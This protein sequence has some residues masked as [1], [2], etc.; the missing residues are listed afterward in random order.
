MTLVSVLRESPRSSMNKN[1]QSRKRYAEHRQCLKQNLIAKSPCFQIKRIQQET[2]IGRPIPDKPPPPYTPPER[3]SQ[4]VVP[5]PV[6]EKHV[7]CAR[8]EIASFV[9]PLAKTLYA[10]KFGTEAPNVDPPVAK[11]D[12]AAMHPSKK[13]FLSFLSDFTAEIF[14]EIYACEREEQNPPWMPQKPLAK[15]LRA[16]P[17]SSAE[18]ED[19][20]R[21]EALIHFGLE[22][23]S[24]KEN[25]IVRWSQRKRDR[26]DQILVRE[27][28]G[29]E[30]GWTDYSK[31]EALVKDQ[32]SKAILDL[33]ID[34]T[35]KELTRLMS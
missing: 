20:V 33:L 18:L 17:K 25:L 26:V 24:A 12:S 3:V 9:T 35:V 29:E 19:R 32:V 22:R 5:R 1:W 8:D 27:L 13:V 28:H 30:V 11:D 34:D 6:V 7:P 23:R 21:R 31:D 4:P 2:L 15:A 16:L 10:K 14:E